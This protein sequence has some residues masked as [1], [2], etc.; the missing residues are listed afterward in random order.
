MQHAGGGWTGDVRIIDWQEVEQAQRRTDI[1]IKR[2]KAD[3][4]ELVK[5]EKH[6][7]FPVK[8]GIL[9]MPEDPASDRHRR[10]V[11]VQY[12][13]ERHS[14]PRADDEPRS[15]STQPNQ[16]RPQSPQEQNPLDIVAE[17]PLQ[18]QEDESED[19]WIMHDFMLMRHHRS[20]R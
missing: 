4:V 6:I 1:H 19:Y 14:E 12:E 20:P 9:V 10:S 5:T 8:T 18:F 7:F 2:M 13:A 11:Q 15:Q 16:E 3:E 17:A